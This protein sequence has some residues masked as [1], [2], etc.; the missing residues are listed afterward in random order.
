M[1]AVTGFALGR[2]SAD[3]DRDLARSARAFAG[4]QND[5]S[6]LDEIA[7]LRAEL[8]TANATNQQ[9]YNSAL[10]WRQYAAGLEEQIEALMQQ[11]R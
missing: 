2:I 10:S 1:D 3:Y 4:I 5:R 9:N 8:V 6:L 7:R 11:V